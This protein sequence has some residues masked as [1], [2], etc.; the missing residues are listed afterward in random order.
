MRTFGSAPE[1]GLFLRLARTLGLPAAKVP[2]TKTGGFPTRLAE[3][4]I[5]TGSEHCNLRRSGVSRRSVPKPKYKSQRN[6][7]E[8][9]GVHSSTFVDSGMGI[10]LNESQ[11]AGGLSIAGDS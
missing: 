9:I 1:S 7:N 8:A 6:Q 5:E 11:V 3:R 10:R 2:M 4:Y